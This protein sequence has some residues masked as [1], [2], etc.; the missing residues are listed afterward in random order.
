MVESSGS[1]PCTKCGCCC[2]MLNHPNVH[3][4]VRPLALPDGSGVCRHLSPDSSCAIYSTRP[5]PCNFDSIRARA[6]V[7]GLTLP[8]TDW[9]V[10]LARGSCA[11]SIDQTATPDQDLIQI[12]PLHG[13][14][15]SHTRYAQIHKYVHQLFSNDNA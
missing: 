7:L 5:W 1:F 11:V 6:S 10:F 14:T 2:R 13:A 12:T 15:M 8:L 3:P 9:H 4:L